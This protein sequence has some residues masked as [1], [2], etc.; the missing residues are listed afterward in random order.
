MFEPKQKIA[1]NP[2][3]RAVPIQPP[4]EVHRR[5]ARARD[6]RVSYR[7]STSS[8]DRPPRKRSR[9]SRSTAPRRDSADKS[10]ALSLPF[11][12]TPRRAS[13]KTPSRRDISLRHAD[14]GS[15]V[16]PLVSGLHAEEKALASTSPWSTVNANLSSRR[17]RLCIDARYAR[18]TGTRY[19][20]PGSGGLSYGF[21]SGARGRFR[22]P[23]KRQRHSV[24]S[25]AAVT[26]GCSCASRTASATSSDE[27]ESHPPVYRRL[28]APTPIANSIAREWSGR[29]DR[30]T[31]LRRCDLPSTGV[32]AR[33][34]HG[35]A[36][37][38]LPPTK[39]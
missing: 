15:I 10:S 1:C 21:C 9:S 37:D 20:T 30:A 25:R 19:A 24:S 34:A 16:F 35:H 22:D 13:S 7:A 14:L 12:R 18:H 4:R 33:R 39:A 28:V 23:T 31:K 17:P 29:K 38:R 27:C 26:F 11:F 3:Q 5:R 6:P 32:L 8:S 36:G 2:T